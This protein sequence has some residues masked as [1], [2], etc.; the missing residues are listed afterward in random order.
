ME[1]QTVIEQTQRWLQE[2]VLGL[3]LCPFAA[4]PV[5]RGGVGYRVCEETLDEAIF[6]ALMEE[7]LAFAA[8]PASEV[9]TELWIV[10]VGLD[11]FDDY[12]DL[13][14]AAEQALE[15]L[16]LAGEIQLASFHPRYRFQDAPSDDPAN[17]S[18]RSPYPMFH[19]L[20]EAQLEQALASYPDPEGIPQRNV[21]RLRD[22]G[23]DELERRLARILDA[24]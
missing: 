24:E 11:L 4:A 13:L 1:P 20:R 18:N 8:Q 5:Q 10:P 3:N 6:R 21:E 14:Y 7:I 16:G 17:Y 12:L 22:L 9:E 23:L 2:L 15:E 19:L